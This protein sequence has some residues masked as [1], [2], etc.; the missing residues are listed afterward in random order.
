[1]GRRTLIISGLLTSCSLFGAPSPSEWDSYCRK[2][3]IER[4]INSLYD[5]STK[6]HSKTSRSCVACHPNKGI[7]GHLKRSAESFRLL[8]QDIT[9]PP[10][11]RPPKNSPMT[12][13]DCFVCH[14]F[15]QDIEEVPQGKLPKSVRQI[16]LRAAHSQHWDYRTFTPEQ[17][18][19]LKS[20]MAQKAKS[21]LAKAER[22][23][24]DHL[25]QIE[26][27]QCSRCH[28]RFRKDSPGS[29][30][31]NVN[32]AMKNPMEC[33]ACHIAL[34]SSIHPGD[35]SRFPSA[36]SCERCHHGA[37]HQTMKFFPLDRTTSDE[38]LLCHPGYSTDELVA[39]KPDAFI[40]K[41]T[42]T[43]NISKDP[44]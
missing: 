33:T 17:K 13:D 23:Q 8:F 40:H 36:V 10:D 14:P 29:V 24:L 32:I 1:M 30:N 25:S 3:H 44:E 11:I 18:S 39:I 41:S 12:S 34:R 35:A 38:C 42:G 16:K 28:E 21:P 43:N 26:K 15:F 37:L 19:K 4:P 7:A 6:T 2:C 5:S 20:L 27:M 22:D 31:L 9:L